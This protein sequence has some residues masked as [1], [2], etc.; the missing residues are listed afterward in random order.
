ME[1]FKQENSKINLFLQRKLASSNNSMETNIN[2]TSGNKLNHSQF[3]NILRKIKNSDFKY[4]SEE[5]NNTHLEISIKDNS[6]G[7]KL[8]GDKNISKYCETNKIEESIDSVEITDTIRGRDNKLSIGN[9]NLY[10]DLK[11]DKRVTRKSARGEK[12]IS[13]LFKYDKYYRYLKT[14]SFVSK[15][16]LFQINFNISKSSYTDEFTDKGGKMLKKDVKFFKKKFVKKPKEDNRSFSE[17]WNSLD[18]EAEVSL[19]DEKYIKKI[20]FKSLDSSGTLENELEY[21]IKVIFLGGEIKGNKKEKQEIVYTSYISLLERILKIIQQSNH[22]ISQYEIRQMKGKYKT[23]TKQFNFRQSMPFS[24]TLETK[25]IIRLSSEEYEE[26]VN[27]RKHYCVTEKADG[28]RNLM[29]IDDKGNVF[30]INR[31]DLVRKTGMIVKN[32]PN[33]LL[34]GEYVTKLKGGYEVQ[35]FLIFDLYFMNG[36]D[37]RERVLMRMDKKNE[38]IPKSRLEVLEE[39]LKEIDIDGE[40][41]IELRKKDFLYGDYSNPSEKGLQRIEQYEISLDN[42][43]AGSS[44]YNSNLIEL[45]KEYKDTKIFQCADEIIDRIKNG[46]FEYETDGLILTPVNLT[47][48]E[49]P[50]INKRNKYGGRWGRS[51]K[52][53]KGDENSID[54]MVEFAKDKNGEFVDKVFIDDENKYRKIYLKVAYD[55]KNML[56]NRAKIVNENPVYME[57]YN[58]IL[59][60]PTTNF[61]P[62]TF[63][64]YL[65]LTN[66]GGLVCQG[67]GNVVGDVIKEGSIIEFYYDY[68]PNDK[69]NKDPR[70]RWVPMRKRDNVV[71]NSFETAN[72]I[73]NTIF[74]PISEES[75]KTGKFLNKLSSEYYSGNKKEKNI[76]KS[77]H[78]LLKKSLINSVVTP[79]ATLLD[80]GAGECGDLHKWLGTDLSAVIG[81]EYNNY[82]INNNVNGGFKRIIQAM[83]SER[84][85]DKE[86]VKNIF[87]IWGDGGKNILDGSCGMDKLNKFYLD[88]LMGNSLDREMKYL[89]R[90]PKL[91]DNIGRFKGGFNIISSQFCMHYFFKNNNTLKEFLINLN[92]NLVVGGKFIA[93][94]FDARKIFNILDKNEEIE[95]RNES[96]KIIW[97]ISK[98][99]KDKFLPADENSLGMSV[100]VY[101]NTFNKME[102]EYLMNIDYLEKVLPEFGLELE[103]CEPF[104]K[105]YNEFRANGTLEEELS[106]ESKEFSFLNMTLQIVKKSQYDNMVGGGKVNVEKFLS[107]GDLMEEV[108]N[109]NY[110]LKILNDDDDDVEDGEDGEV[111][112]G[113]VLNLDKVNDN[114]EKITK[115]NIK[116]NINELIGGGGKS[117]D[118]L[119]EIN[120][121]DTTLDLSGEVNFNNTPLKEVN[122]DEPKEVNLDDTASELKEVNFNDTASELKEVNF[123]EPKEVNLDDT[124]SELKEVNF[125]DT[126]EVNFN[127]LKEV[128][129]DNTASE[130]KEVNFDEP[131]EVNL[132]QPKDVKFSQPVENEHEVE[133]RQIISPNVKVIKITGDQGTLNMI[134]K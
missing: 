114:S 77:F 74:E 43:V 98:K 89:L 14:Y 42:L 56:V 36:E 128:N 86:L 102:D 100:G 70:F 45:E 71:P 37:F 64:C 92:Q 46:D 40:N 119:N 83:N 104:E 51:F 3:T 52:W 5:G 80:I 31:Q 26:N 12:V 8:Y 62:R 27:I 9:Y 82:N 106:D 53:K 85:A 129:F 126:K 59:F 76:F 123:N 78:N 38:E 4:Q 117:E 108:D 60:E 24:K 20:P 32:F 16:S 122:F 116:L 19:S 63:E 111:T 65:K 99:Y 50:E 94:C 132:N 66:N 72:N 44:E 11:E 115:Q 131:I 133:P 49:E 18:N 121:E 67:N 57:G 97:K 124:A 21:D 73:W 41:N 1:L 22:L 58:S 35:L 7:L 120:F 75:I 127:E 54:F 105:Y 118:N 81:I 10:I 28:E 101:V 96:G 130:L 91:K 39:M 79:G 93:T 61:V 88:V 6:L 55:K 15:D 125:N 68:N 103:T 25:N 110:G 48:G 47:V 90:N 107:N 87:L 33:S 17:W 109:E 34:D 95:Q 84:Y 113:N 23:L 2:S 134:N 30:L 29:Y 112:E 69:I 13:E